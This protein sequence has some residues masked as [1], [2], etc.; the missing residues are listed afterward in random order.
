VRGV[1]MKK[2]SRVSPVVY[3]VRTSVGRTVPRRTGNA[4]SRSD[5]C[6]ERVHLA[7]LEPATFGSVEGSSQIP[8]DSASTTSGNTPSGVAPGVA[9]NAPDP[10]LAHVVE[11]WPALPDAIRRAVLALVGS[12][13]G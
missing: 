7:G 11:A 12:A 10:D 3:R 13:N 1:R 8:T 5:L 4:I 6:L 9:R 2:A